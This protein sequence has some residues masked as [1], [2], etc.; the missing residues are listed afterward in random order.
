MR[1]LVLPLILLLTACPVPDDDDFADDDSADDDDGS[2][3]DDAAID[4]GSGGSGGIVGE[5]TG[6]ADGATYRFFVPQSYD[7]STPVP[8]LVGLHGS[9]GNGQIMTGVWRS[10]AEEE[11]FVVLGPDWSDPAGWNT[12]GDIDA[13]FATIGEMAASYDL[14]L[15]RV[16]LNGFSA[17]AH[18]TYVL[19]LSSS[20]VFAALAPY[21]GSMSYAEQMGI[22]PDDVTRLV[23]ARIDHGMNDTVVPFSEAE[24]ARDEL[25]AAG[26]AVDFNG[27]PGSGHT[28]E[29]SVTGPMWES[30][31]QHA[32]E[33][34]AELPDGARDELPLHTIR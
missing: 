28:W 14:D 8:L 2:D 6:T 23:P 3:D 19:G 7:G 30:L 26:H 25:E 22:W 27:I 10:V 31:A 16:Y 1:L 17:G 13:I 18:L 12:G 34:P 24:H 9:G 32:L 4:C 29:N 21:A 20:E 15:C 11:G 5:G 33:A